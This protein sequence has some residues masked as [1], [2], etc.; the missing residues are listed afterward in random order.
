MNKLLPLLLLL[1]ACAEHLSRPRAGWQ[2][3]GAKGSVISCRGKE[4]ARVEC[5]EPEGEVCGTLAVL[6]AGGERVTLTRRRARRPELQPDGSHLWY[7]AG[8]SHTGLWSLYDLQS[9][10]MQEV[11]LYQIFEWHDPD[12]IPL[13]RVR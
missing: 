1:A 6:Y 8:D 5:G 3:C 10:V 2:S 13:W 9:G 11:D 12:S 4:V 7:S